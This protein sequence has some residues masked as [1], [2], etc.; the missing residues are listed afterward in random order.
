MSSVSSILTAAFISA[1]ITIEKDI[2]EVSRF[3]TPE[4]YGLVNLKS[5]PKKCTVCALV[6]VIAACQ[7]AS[8][9]VSVALSSV[10]NRTILVM[11]LSIDV[12]FA[13]VLKVMRVDFFYWLPIESVPVRFSASLIERIVIKVIT[14]FTACMQMRH[15]LEL[16]GAYFTAVLLT[17]PLVSLYFGSR[18]LSYV[19]DEEA[20]ATL[21]SIYSSE[22][23]YGFLGALQ[24]FR[25]AA[26]RHFYT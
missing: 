13:L 1:S 14:D 15:P 23:V 24:G 10:E 17:T 16:G 26:W 7:L 2:D 21:S 8:K 19:E 11:Y 20:K 6:L 12:G 3:H 18:Y 22:Q 4:F 25:C 9:A 5:V